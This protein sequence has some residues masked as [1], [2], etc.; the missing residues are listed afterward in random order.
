MNANVRLANESDVKALAKLADELIPMEDRKR[1]EACL[2]DSIKDSKRDIYVVEIEGGLAGF[3]E[4]Y[5]FPDFVHGGEIAL[6]QNLAIAREHRGRGLGDEL[7]AQAVKRAG[8]RGALEVHAWTDF[9]NKPAI[10]LYKKYGL[11]KEYLLLEK[12]FQ[13]ET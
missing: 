7:M 8:E 13:K 3:L 12:E 10:G 1:R 4:L 6:I 9:E 5:T 2:T 11:A